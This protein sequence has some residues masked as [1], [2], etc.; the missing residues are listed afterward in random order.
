MAQ[1]I[2]YLLCYLNQTFDEI[3]LANGQ[4]PSSLPILQRLQVTEDVDLPCLVDQSL[5]IP[6]FFAI[7]RHIC[8]KYSREDLLGETVE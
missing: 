6:D 1:I 8:K 5:I 3:L 4:K 7:I 2:R